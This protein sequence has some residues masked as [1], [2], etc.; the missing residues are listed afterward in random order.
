[1]ELISREAVL[2]RAREDRIPCD[3]GEYSHWY[4]DYNDI[5]EIP[6]IEERL[7]ARW[8]YKKGI[9]YCSHCENASYTFSYYC[10][11]CG[12]SMKDERRTNGY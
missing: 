11:W 1:M 6:T 5:L 2:Y 3:G 9:I 8:I 10:P 7:K 12:A 4:V